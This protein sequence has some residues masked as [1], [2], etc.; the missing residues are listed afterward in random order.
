MRR[1]ALNRLLLQDA[2]PRTI[3]DPG[4]RRVLRDLAD[5]AAAGELLVELPADAQPVEAAL[6]TLES[7]RPDRAAAGGA[8]LLGAGSASERRA[9]LH[10]AAGTAVAAAVELPAPVSATGIALAA[11]PLAPGMVLDLEV[12]EDWRGLPSG[13]A[14]LAGSVA[15]GAVGEPAI[16]SAAAGPATIGAGLHW[17]VVRCRAGAAVWLAAAAGADSRTARDAGGGWVAGAALPATRAGVRAAR[18]RRGR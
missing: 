10:V 11:L 14:L 15:L 13:R 3:L 2:Y 7:L 17:A 18:A 1:T 9:G 4:E 8:G 6:P 12:Q 16:V 5:P